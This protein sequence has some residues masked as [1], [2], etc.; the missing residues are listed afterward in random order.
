ML[1]KFKEIMNERVMLIISL[2]AVLLYIYLRG[3]GDHGLFDAVEGVNASVS[4]N[5]LSHSNYLTPKIGLINFTGKT[6][7]L[8]LLNAL[9]LKIFGW[10]E[11]AVRFWPALSG[12]LIAL[13]AYL[14]TETRRGG[15][16]AAII[17]AS[18]TLCFVSS[19][20]S[21]SYSLYACCMGCALDGFI[22]FKF[23]W[24]FIAS[25]SA[26][27]IQG[28]EGLIMPWMTL[29]LFSL[30]IQD[31]EV[32][33]LAFKNKLIVLS[34]FIALAGY[35]ILIVIF[36]PLILTLMLY[37]SPLL[38][39]LNFLNYIFIIVFAFTPWLGFLIL[40]FW[41]VLPKNLFELESLSLYGFESRL[42]TAFW[43]LIFFIFAIISGDLLMMTACI[44]AAGTL[45]GDSLDEWLETKR[46][47]KLQ[48]SAALNSLILILIIFIALPC[49][50]KFTPILKGSEM[51]LIPW[52]VFIFIFIIISRYF[53][54]RRKIIKITRC[55][56]LAALA[57]LMPL[58]GIFDLAASNFSLRESGLILR[59]NLKQ[60]NLMI[61]YDMHRPS[62][63]FYSLGDYVLSQNS[64][65][66]DGVAA[67]RFRAGDNNIS[68]A[69]QDAAR[70]FLVV[71][72]S[73]NFIPP[74]PNNTFSVLENQ[75]EKIIVLS[76]H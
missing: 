40:A 7:G 46:F 34:A 24:A 54:R 36:N 68:L 69:W 50:W 6:L 23:L 16:L 33:K 18:M 15:I 44:P 29:F 51:S 76:N 41:E 25:I 61:Q 4:L 14:S 22:N 63:Y 30:L 31:F 75:R 72:K 2:A 21:A 17:S 42:F 73:N 20:L 48:N 10:N 13:A 59:D 32:L 57:C 37:K 28:P 52:A 3:I 62:L 39:D 70:Y 5:M 11:F 56:M 66:I 35:L 53:A 27:I 26:F 12:V 43:L 1:R 19:Q 9:S 64:P 55:I 71:D 38:I 58:A 49:A 65:E 74:L 47:A 60:N 67:K 8:W 45:I